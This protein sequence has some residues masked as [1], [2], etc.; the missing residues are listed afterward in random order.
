MRI[1][2]TG[3]TRASVACVQTFRGCKRAGKDPFVGAH[4][5]RRGCE[6]RWLRAEAPLAS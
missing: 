2:F 1:L 3:Q 6:H 4:W 5:F